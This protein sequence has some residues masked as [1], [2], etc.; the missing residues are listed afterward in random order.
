MKKEVFQRTFSRRKVETKVLNRG[1][2]V[3][4]DFDPQ[5]GAEIMKRRPALVVSPGSYNNKS[6]LI[7]CCPITSTIINSPWGVLLPDNLKVSGVI[8]S[9]HVSSMDQRARKA[10]KI[11][12]APQDVTNEVMQKI[13]ALL[14]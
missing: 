4:I 13:S 8:L 2:L 1:D 7:L 9:N 10:V 6:K 14:S 11:C 5:A 3:Y 12:S